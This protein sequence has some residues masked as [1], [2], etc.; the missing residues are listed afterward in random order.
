[1]THREQGNSRWGIAAVVAVYLV[2]SVTMALTVPLWEAPDEPAHYLRIRDEARRLGL[3]DGEGKS[4]WLFPPE[5]GQPPAGHPGLPLQRGRGFWKKGTVVSPYERHQ[6]P[7]YYLLA[8]PV[9][10][11]AGGEAEPPFFFNHRYGERQ[12]QVFHHGADR[13]PPFAGARRAILILRLLST[14]IG[15]ATV[16]LIWRL[17]GRLFPGP[18]GR[19]VALTAAA[20]TAFLPQFI[21]ITSVINNDAL[22]IC[23][24]A[25]FLNLLVPQNGAPRYG[26]GRIVALVLVLAAALLTDH[27]LAVLLPAALAWTAGTARSAFRRRLA[28]GAL[29]IILLGG[30]FLVAAPPQI[31]GGAPWSPQRQLDRLRFI[32]HDLLE[33]DSMLDAARLFFTSG[34]GVFGWMSVFPPFL[35]TVAYLLVTTLVLLGMIRLLFGRAG[36]DGMRPG[37]RPLFLVALACLALLVLRNALFTFQ[38]QGRLLFPLLPLAAPLTAAGLQ[39][40]GPNIPGRLG[41]PVALFMAGASLFSLFGLI[42]PAYPPVAAP[43]P[44]TL[45]GESAILYGLHGAG[46]AVETFAGQATTARLDRTAAFRLHNP[47]DHPATASLRFTAEPEGAPSTLQLWDRRRPLGEFRLETGRRFIQLDR[48]ALPPGESVVFFHLLPEEGAGR[49]RVSGLHLAPPAGMTPDRPALKG[50]TDGQ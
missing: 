46:F 18:R 11:L 23:L 27:T 44:F 2:L 5:N 9:L 4:H 33:W 40:I 50:Q 35:L 42:R 49:C 12:G 34:W 39:R 31:G 38:P 26:P 6:P 29:V 8:A 17:A 30:L 14:L 20:V 19:V 16:V 41:L 47:G 24:A 43:V 25:L 37:V 10:A 32:G 22:T 21:F 13:D 15:A 48:L 7:G 3:V 45:P 1:M 28:T 36:A